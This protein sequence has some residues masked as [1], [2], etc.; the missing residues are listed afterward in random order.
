[1]KKRMAGCLPL[2]CLPGN[3]S[4][5]RASVAFTAPTAPSTT[6]HVCSSVPIGDPLSPHPLFPRFERR[7]FLPPSERA[8]PFVGRPAVLSV[9][10]VSNDAEFVKVK[11][12]EGGGGSETALSVTAV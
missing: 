5:N 3:A 12:K 8:A 2:V 10:L 11:P 6:R 9:A 1:M 4:G 7:Y